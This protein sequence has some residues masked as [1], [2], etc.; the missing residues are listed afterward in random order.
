MGDE[1]ADEVQHQANGSGHASSSSNDH[2]S[3]ATLQ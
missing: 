3:L 1:R 2:V